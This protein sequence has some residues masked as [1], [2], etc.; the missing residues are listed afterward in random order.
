MVFLYSIFEVIDMQ[1]L[2]RIQGCLIGGVIGDSLGLPAKS[3]L[4]GQYE[5]WGQNLTDQYR[6]NHQ[7]DFCNKLVEEFRNA[8]KIEFCETKIEDE[9]LI[10]ET[11]YEVIES[12]IRRHIESSIGLAATYGLMYGDVGFRITKQVL[13]KLKLDHDYVLTLASLSMILSGLKQNKNIETVVHDVIEKLSY[14]SNHSNVTDSL[15]MALNL[16]SVDVDDDAALSMIGKTRIEELLAL[17]VYCSYKYCDDFQKALMVA[18]SHDGNGHL[19]GSLTG[20]I[21]GTLL[22]FHAIPM[23]WLDSVSIRDE[24][25]D[26]SMNLNTELYN[27]RL[28]IQKK[29]ES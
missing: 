22:G 9:C 21:T 20:Y 16:A 7:L 18:I 29:H 2:M 17:A 5:G 13:N 14:E 27:Q 25:I 11:G 8:N 19:S 26:L 24:L 4:N 3:D 15:L 23:Y 1:N 6:Y 12:D 28:I 10:V